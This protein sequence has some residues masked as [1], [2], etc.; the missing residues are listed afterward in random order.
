MAPGTISTYT[1]SSGALD[2][3][4][5]VP[6]IAGNS[7]LAADPFGR[8]LYTVSPSLDELYSYSMV[9]SSGALTALTNPASSL[10]TSP[11]SLVVVSFRPICV[12]CR[13]GPVLRVF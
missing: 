7:L 3:V 10:T 1:I 11:T 8:F 12:C 9:A 5:A 2:F 13:G 6:G 4:S